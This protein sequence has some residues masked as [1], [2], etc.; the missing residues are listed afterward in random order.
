MLPVEH[1]YSIPG[2]G[3]VVTG[4]LERGIIKKGNECEF[5]GYNKVIKSTITGNYIKYLLIKAKIDN[6]LI[7]TYTQ[8]L[9]YQLLLLNKK[10]NCNIFV[11]L[12]F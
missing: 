7:G 1:V 12:M 11:Y 5:V 8:K 6:R 2:R 10:V 9:L 3:T 4:R